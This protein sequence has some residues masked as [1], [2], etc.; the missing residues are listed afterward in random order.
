MTSH[1]KK[2]LLIGLMCF[3]NITTNID[4]GLP[5]EDDLFGLLWAKVDPAIPKRKELAENVSNTFKRLIPEREQGC[6]SE[7]IGQFGIDVYDD[8]CARTWIKKGEKNSDE[9]VF[10][11]FD[12]KPTKQGNKQICGVDEAIDSWKKSWGG[13]WSGKSK[14]VVLR[15][16]LWRCLFRIIIGI[17]KQDLLVMYF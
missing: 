8:H 4:C 15:K 13:N 5:N 1:L 11:T 16:Q 3:L 2:K 6:W 12:Y 17:T 9:Q 10:I 7:K 14:N